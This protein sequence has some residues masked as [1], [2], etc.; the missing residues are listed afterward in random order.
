MVVIIVFREM[1]PAA[2]PIVVTT[3]LP[4]ATV[5]AVRDDIGVRHSGTD[6]AAEGGAE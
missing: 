3:T 6:V 1:A 4:D 2:V 5:D